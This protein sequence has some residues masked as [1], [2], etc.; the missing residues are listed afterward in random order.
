MTE[1]D[2]GPLRQGLSRSLEAVGAF[3]EPWLRTVFDKVPRHLFVPDTV[4]TWSGER[5]CPLRRDDDPEQWG[6]LIYDPDGAGV[7]TQVNEGKTDEDGCGLVP[8]SSLSS[9]GAVLE[10][11]HSLDPRPGE[12]V[13]EIGTGTGY[14]AALLCERVGQDHVVTIEVDE[15]VA[16]A[17]RRRLRHCGYSPHV[18]VAN[19]ENGFAPRRPYPRVMSTA[20]VR[21]IP[22]AWLE[23][24]EADGELVTPWLPNHRGVGLLWLRKKD[25]NTLKGWVHGTNTFMPVRG[26]RI[27]RPDLTGLWNETHTKAVQLDRVISMDDVDHHGGFVLA[28]TLP[29]ISSF[30]QDDGW[31]LV[32]LDRSQWCR[33]SCDSSVVEYGEGD[34]ASRLESALKWWRERDRPKYHDFGVTVGRKSASETSLTV[35]YD[36]GDETPVPQF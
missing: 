6:R 1:F 27:E 19:G 26:Q 14:N 29:G 33:V 22:A 10:M 24:M 7:V 20:S 4:Y 11:L 28:A 36:D 32:T 15:G 9:V 30:R 13:L 8:T 12:P 3:R 35:W 18:V 21:Q 31:F 17:A 16:L 2:F 34:L 5:W 25:R 23:Q